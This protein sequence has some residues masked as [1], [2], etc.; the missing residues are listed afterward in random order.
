MTCLRQSESSHMMPLC[1]W[2]DFFDVAAPTPIKQQLYS[3]TQTPSAS[4][5]YVSNCL[6]NGCISTSNG[7]ALS[8]TSVSYLLIESSSFFSCKISDR[9]GGAIYFV[10]TNSGQCVLYEVC[11]YDCCSTSTSRTDGQFARVD[12]KNVISSKNY[13][14]YSSITRCVNQIPES[15]FTFY[16][17]NGKI[18]CSSANISM[19]KCQHFSGYR[20]RPFQDSSSVTCSTLYSS[21][22]DNE[23]SVYILIA[24]Y[25]Y[26]NL[27]EIK[28][29]NILRNT[30]GSLSSIGTI[31]AG[32]NAI[33]EDSCILENRATYIFYSTSYTV[34]LTNCTI[35][36]TTYTGNLNIRNT[37]TKSFIIALNHMS[38]RYCYAEYD[39]VGT[40]TAIPYVT[41]PTKKEICYTIKIF[42]YNQARI[43]DVFSLTWVFMVTFIHP[44]SC[45]NY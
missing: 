43:S 36:K 30:Q 13:I 6:F 18:C 17:N 16:L 3:S 38:T 42:N 22:A 20:F 35:D 7:G 31:E 5:V 40:L 29:C 12:V 9:Y 27:F 41:H 34:T 45:G 32:G 37:V 4:S 39:S 8:C 44:N 19:N 28:C 2:S 10:N 23:A 25:M 33:I 15:Y 24:F 1:F 26:G 11:G 21:F 14:N